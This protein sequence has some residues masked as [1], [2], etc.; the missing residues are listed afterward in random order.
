MAEKTVTVLLCGFMMI[1]LMFCT[2]ANQPEEKEDA[3]Y[4]LDITIAGSGTVTAGDAA[5]TKI[6]S[7]KMDKDREVT[8]SA[9]PLSGWHFVEWTGDCSG[10]GACTL[11]LTENR[12][13]TAI[14]SFP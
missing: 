11:T 2:T 13:V 8:L 14:F 3:A 6:C 10:S 7:F 9:K 1:F 4:R 12:S 5:C